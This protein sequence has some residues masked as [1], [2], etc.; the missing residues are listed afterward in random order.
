LSRS[1]GDKAAVRGID[2]DVS[3]GSILGLLGPNGAGK[4]TVVRML[5]T[6][7][8]PSGGPAHVD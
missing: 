6:L 7:L 2:L 4:T 1:F 8:A 5:T 3:K